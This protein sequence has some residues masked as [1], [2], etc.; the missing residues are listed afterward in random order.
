MMIWKKSNE[1]V[2]KELFNSYN[3]YL[4]KIGLEMFLCFNCFDSLY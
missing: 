2:N 3:I 1:G 4:R